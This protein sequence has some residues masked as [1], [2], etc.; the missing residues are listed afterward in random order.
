VVDSD[1]EDS[2]DSCID[3]Y[4]EEEEDNVFLLTH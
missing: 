2:D 1:S 3:L 4:G